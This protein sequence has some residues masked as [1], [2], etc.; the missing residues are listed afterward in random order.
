MWRG[1][2]EK[3]TQYFL[4]CSRPNPRLCY[5]AHL[6]HLWSAAHSRRLLTISAGKK[7]IEN[8]MFCFCIL[9]FFECLE[10]ADIL[11]SQRCIC[12]LLSHFRPNMLLGSSARLVGL[13]NQL[14]FLATI[15][16]HQD[17]Q[18]LQKSFGFTSKI[19]SKYSQVVCRDGSRYFP[20]LLLG[21]A[22]PGLA[23][24]PR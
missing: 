23:D 11:V 2:S 20:S 7:T 21:L 4:M 16:S 5:A 3:N 12:M 1:G 13:G 17:T 24:I 8:L 19:F 6:K 10:V 14:S 15:P 18:V 9:T 22:L